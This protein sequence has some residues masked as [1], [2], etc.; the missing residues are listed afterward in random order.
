MSTDNVARFIR[1]VA[2]KPALNKK[3]ALRAREVEAW[4][5]CATEA[6]FPFS[7]AELVSFAAE[8]SGRDLS[9]QEAIPA[10][11]ADGDGGSHALVQVG[12]GIAMCAPAVPPIRF[13]PAAL[14]RV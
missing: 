13:A 1:C 11:L 3:L 2:E 5:A 8:V 6:G 14:A 10:L 12:F 9:E 7:S 4:V